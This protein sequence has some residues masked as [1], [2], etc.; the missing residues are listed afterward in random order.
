MNE[1]WKK[2]DDWFWEGNIQA[3][4]VDSLLKEGYLV[5]SADTLLKQRGPDIVAK[6]GNETILFEIKGWPAGS[7]VDGP[8]K[9]MPKKAPAILQARHWF[10]EALLTLMIAKTSFPNYSLILGLPDFQRYRNLIEQTRRAIDLLG[11]KIWFVT[12][13][14]IVTEE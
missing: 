2:Q 3:R 8:R 13:N 12:E 4:I 10:G 9:G 6:K 1:E 7:I 14:G 11:L 5:D